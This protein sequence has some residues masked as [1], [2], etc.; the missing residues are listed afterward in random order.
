MVKIKK[1]EGSALLSVI[2]GMIILTFVF[3]GLF[4]AVNGLTTSAKKM[5]Q[6]NDEYVNLK[7]IVQM[8]RGKSYDKLVDENDIAFNDKYKYSIQ[9]KEFASKE[10]SY[11]VATINIFYKNE[12]GLDKQQ[13]FIVNKVKEKFSKDTITKASLDADNI[14]WVY[15]SKDNYEQGDEMFAFA[16]NSFPG[17]YWRMPKHIDLKLN[18]EEKYYFLH[19]KV[20]DFEACG[21]LFGEI[22]LPEDS[23]F[24][25]EGT[26]TKQIFAEPVNLEGWQVSS[27]G[28][29]DYI[30]P[31]EN[32][33]YAWGN[34]L[35]YNSENDRSREGRR[36]AYFSTKIINTHSNIYEL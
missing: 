36:E 9:V 29:E 8:V 31:V 7:S 12:E 2:M 25:F 14:F 5:E 30:T 26:G 1:T 34:S 13:T 22:S 28:W 32:Y 10:T 15:L 33:C 24:I 20:A 6:V 27:K 17:R 23:D 16:T 35:W 21:G 18:G 3:S 19:I 4:Y 11:K